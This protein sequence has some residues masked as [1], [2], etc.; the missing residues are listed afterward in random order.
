MTPT[1]IFAFVFGQP[2]LTTRCELAGQFGFPGGHQ[3][4]GESYFQCAE[5][6]TLE[7]TGLKIK[8]TKAFAV[9]NTV[10]D[11]EHHYIT[12]FVQCSQYSPLEQPQVSAERDGVSGWLSPLVTKL[13]SCLLTH[14]SGFG[15]RKMS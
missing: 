14:L 15:A 11:R 7:E 3:E 13:V 12:V 4:F 6:E 9:A 1:T 5:R 8:A 10:F 2:T